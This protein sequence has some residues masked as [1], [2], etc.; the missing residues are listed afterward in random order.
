MSGEKI[1]GSPGNRKAGRL[2]L[3]LPARLE[4]PRG[5][6]RGV[7]CDVSEGGAKVFAKAGPACGQD[8]LLKWA[9]HEAFGGVVWQ[10]EGFIG[11]AFDEPLAAAIL[12]DTRHMQDAQGMTREQMA[13]WLAETGWAFGKA[14]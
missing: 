14:L 4:T 6:E 5:V 8:V 9:R 2:R 3:R 12:I 13:Q 10:R 11:L 1:L 7:L